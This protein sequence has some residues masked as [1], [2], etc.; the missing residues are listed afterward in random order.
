MTYKVKNKT[1]KE[2]VF[3]FNNGF[4]KFKP[5]EEKKV[6]RSPNK[7]FKQDNFEIEIL[8]NKKSEQ[9]TNNSNVKTGKLKENGKSR[10]L[11]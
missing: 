10:K 9:I 11:E 1:N 6:E 7:S 8:K 5:Q 4:I 2:Q 3:F